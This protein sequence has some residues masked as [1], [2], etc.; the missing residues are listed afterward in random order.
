MK[1]REWGQVFFCVV[2]YLA[3]V[4]FILLIIFG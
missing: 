1:L 2:L 3:L 4:A